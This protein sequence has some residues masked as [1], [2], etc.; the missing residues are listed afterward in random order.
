[1]PY[2]IIMNQDNSITV[3]NSQ[4]DPDSVQIHDLMLIVGHKHKFQITLI[5]TVC[6]C[7]FIASSS[8]DLITF[9]FQN[10]KFR[11]PVNP[12]DGLLR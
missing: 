11:C 10:L 1:M 6:L 7:M 9:G 8:G 4:D 5:A 2:I 3:Q 12:R